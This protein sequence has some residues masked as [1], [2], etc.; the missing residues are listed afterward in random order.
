MMK[1]LLL[2]LF[3]TPTLAFAQSHKDNQAKFYLNRLQHF[4]RDL[5]TVDFTFFGSEINAD[6]LKE[7]DI[8]TVTNGLQI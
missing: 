1:I 5:E 3:I 2:A 8:R 7:N 4:G 6:Q